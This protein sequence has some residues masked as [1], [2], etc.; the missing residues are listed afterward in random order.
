MRTS[1]PVDQDCRESTCDGSQQDEATTVSTQGSSVARTSV[2]PHKLK[3]A[4]KTTD[5]TTQTTLF[6]LR[7]PLPEKSQSSR[8]LQLDKTQTRNEQTQARYTIPRDIFHMPSHDGRSPSP[9]DP[10]SPSLR[11]IVVEYYKD[12]NPYVILGDALGQPRRRGL[13]QTDDV[14]SVSLSMR[15]R[16]ISLLDPIDR[17]YFHQ[18]RVHELPPK[19]VW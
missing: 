10:P 3:Y 17:A 6:L 15:E 11:R 16:E 13:V 4:M 14:T 8:L 1:S 12:F 9:Q 19:Q 2:P 5:A 18:R 7:S